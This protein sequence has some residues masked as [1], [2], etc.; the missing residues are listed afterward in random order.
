MH[1]SL[2]FNTIVSSYVTPNLNKQKW[3]KTSK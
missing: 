2:C 1:Y 3:G